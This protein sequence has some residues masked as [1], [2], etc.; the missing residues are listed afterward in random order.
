MPRRWLLFLWLVGAGAVAQ[1]LVTANGLFDGRALLT[2]DGRAQMLRAGQVS[3]EGVRLVS[4]T[5]REAVIEIDG[6]R[7][8]LVLS[9]EIGAAYTAPARRQ[10]PVPRNEHGQYRVGGS[11]NGHATMLVVDTGANV[12]ALSGADARRMGI[13]Y[14]RDGTRTVVGTAS[15][16]VEAWNVTLARVET[17][18]ILV[19]NVQASVIEGEHPSPPLLGMSWLSRVGM[20]EE[21]G[22]LYL[23]ER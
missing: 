8:T 5:A 13:D 23:Q 2:I 16:V 14:R 19:R 12:V 18:G 6:R 9:R 4:S 22:V 15:G 17:G 10:V 7:Q 21:A 20:R 11:I 1:P 3:P